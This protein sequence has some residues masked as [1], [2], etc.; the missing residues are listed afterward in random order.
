MFATFA[1]VSAIFALAVAMLLSSGCGGGG[2]DSAFSGLASG[3]G[4]GGTGLGVITGF[5]S[6]IVDGVRHDD[7]LASYTSEEDQGAAVAMAPT[8]A[9]LGHALEFG[10]EASGAMTSVMVSPALVSTVT[11]VNGTRLTVLGTNATINNDTALG[12]VTGLLGY[13]SPAA[14]QIGDRVAVY[15]LFKT[16]A[17]GMSSL[18]ATLIAQKGTGSGIR[19]TGYVAQYNAATGSFVIGGNTINIGSA[20]ISPTGASL[21]NGE[22]VTVWSDAAPVGNVIAAS[23]IRVKLPA[24]ANGER[25]LSGSISAYTGAAN[26]KL[27]N[28]TVDASKASIMPSGASLGDGKYV[29]AVGPFDAIANK[30][31]ATSVTIYAPAASNAVELHGTILNFVSASSFTVR[32]AVV[33]ASAASFSGGSAKDLANN[34][35]VEVTGALANNLVRAATVT[36]LALNPMQA[37]AGAMLDLSGVITSFDAATGSYTMT[38]GSGTT[39]NGMMGSSMFFNNGAAANFAAGQSVNV[40]GMF[41]GSTL[42]TSVVSFTHAAPAQGPGTTPPSSTTPGPIYMEGIAY[43]VT[44]TSFML[45]GL[46]IQINGAPIQGGAMMGSRMMSGSRIGVEVQYSAGQYTAT[47]IK[48]LDG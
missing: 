7:S 41:N 1:R 38:L 33:D 24:A 36:I 44:A 28:V 22:L 4:S 15:G 27:L 37:P 47:S 6:L 20:A 14:I 17:Q 42:S 34:V 46:T 10:Y 8:A 2:A 12:P 31:V 35:F 32:G 11:A 26:F 25:T 23:N 45:N 3:V 5:G 19:L 9:M 13:A 48:L 18:Q 43:N 29:V 40:R 39:L 30:L 16:D 21:S